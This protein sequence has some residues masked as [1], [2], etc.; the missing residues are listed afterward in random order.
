MNPLLYT[1]WLTLLTQETVREERAL[2]LQEYDPESLFER[3]LLLERDVWDY[4]LSLREEYLRPYSFS[5]M[6]TSVPFLEL[7]CLEGSSLH[8]YGIQTS[9]AT[10]PHTIGDVEGGIIGLEFVMRF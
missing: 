4:S 9:N 10:V 1:L 2:H 5:F 8:L 7:P 6:K 3:H